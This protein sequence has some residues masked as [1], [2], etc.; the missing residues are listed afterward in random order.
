MVG[1]VTLWL[2]RFALLAVVAYGVWGIWWQNVQL[3]ALNN[4]MLDLIDIVGYEDVP[5]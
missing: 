5:E 3:E 2:W 1:R 4:A